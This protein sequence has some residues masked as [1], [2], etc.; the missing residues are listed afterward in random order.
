MH[1]LIWTYIE[2]MCPNASFLND[3]LHA[4]I[5]NNLKQSQLRP[6]IE[7]RTP[8]TGTGSK[9]YTVSLKAIIQTYI[10][11]VTIYLILII[12]PTIYFHGFDFSLI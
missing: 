9:Q 6:R 10:T 4:S 11:S 3:T 1:P 2:R 8:G 7:P 5:Y 12:Y